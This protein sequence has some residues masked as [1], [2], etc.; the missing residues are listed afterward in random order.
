MAANRNRRGCRDCWISL[1]VAGG[2]FALVF[3]APVMG[4]WRQLAASTALLAAMAFW[5]D[6]TALKKLLR[7][8][9]PGV[10]RSIVGGLVAAA[11]LYGVF[12][13]G[14]G[15][16]T[17]LFPGGGGLIR[18]IYG[19]GVGVRAWRV[20]LV[21]LLVVGP[22]EEIF[23]RGYIQRRLTETYGF[24]GTI[25][26]VC[27]YTAIHL[28]AWNPVLIL[29]ALVCGAFFGWL[30]WRFGDPVVN[31]VSHAVWAATAFAFLPLA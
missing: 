29:A 24:R 1:A 3:T 21:L 13:V 7:P 22:A 17:A 2:L 28:A 26:T 31:I 30:F 15:V 8:R 27:A 14:R 6:G 25:V 16:V 19:L 11:V 5:F 18:S 9:W 12:L 10:V 4:F 20:G 23:W